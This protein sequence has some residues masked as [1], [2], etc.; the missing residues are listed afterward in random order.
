MNKYVRSREM[1][2][3]SKF[4]RSKLVFILF[5][6]ILVINIYFY[7][8]SPISTSA[9]IDE[10]NIQIIEE[11]L[12]IRNSALLNGNLESIQALYDRNTKL[13]TWA[14]E[15]ELKKMQYLH[16]WA[17]K[18]GII[19]TNIK[20]KFNIRSVKET[21]NTASYNFVCSTEYSYIYEN[22]PEIENLFR[23]GTYHSLKL[24]K[25]GDTWL[26][27]K[28][29]YTDPFADSL[30]LGNL[31]KEEFEEYILS[32][33][34]RDFSNL[35]QRRISAVEYADRY[36]GA[37]ADEEYGF[38]YNKKY[39]DYNPLGGDCANFASQ[40]L[41]EGG[42]FKKNRVWNY[43]KEGSKAWV[44]A[45]AF[46]DYMLNS[47]RASLIAKGTYNQVFKAS[48]K[49]LP[50]DFVAYE[51]NGKV[52]HI[53]VVTGADSKGYSLV[54]CHN[55]D[56]YRVPW[57]LGWSNNNIKFWLVRVHY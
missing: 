32:S 44:N 46:K 31:K 28:E 2:S 38:S 13:G 34:P 30:D 40:I 35:N 55:T 7:N 54:N 27:T 23:I 1:L 36:C 22:E 53:S 16:N 56:R 14:Y 24:Q 6:L 42:K 52:T 39:R 57:D 19:F 8:D 5:M 9:H 33:K 21:D 41:F 47:G 48:F 25:S 12:S 43:T 26:I 37:A 45:Q 18:Q 20:S 10:S 11:L 17:E 49:L 29:W 50:G 51:K 3:L 4:K 15:H